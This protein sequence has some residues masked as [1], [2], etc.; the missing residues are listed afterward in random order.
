MTY[1]NNTAGQCS[2]CMRS[3]RY[4]SIQLFSNTVGL[5]KYPHSF[6]FVCLT[7]MRVIVGVYACVCHCLPDAGTRQCILAG[8][9]SV[10]CAPVLLLK[11]ISSFQG[12]FCVCELLIKDPE[13]D[14]LLVLKSIC[15][16]YYRWDL[17]LLRFCGSLSSFC[18]V[19]CKFVHCFSKKYWFKLFIQNL[20]RCLY[21]PII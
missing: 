3:S 14:M 4:I 19:V 7:C 15:H 5:V 10:L 9:L 21:S 17:G 13:N 16:F 11:G 20:A 8:S 18:F 1:I 12:F 2:V 6:Q